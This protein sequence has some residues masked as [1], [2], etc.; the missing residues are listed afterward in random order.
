MGTIR[1]FLPHYTY[2]DYLQWQGQW[3]VIR[4]IAISMSP[5]PSPRHQEI[6]GNI[7]LLL[8]T[9]VKLK[10]CKQCKV[11]QPIDYKISEDTILNPDLLVV[12]KPVEG[13]F[14]DFPPELVV[15]ILSPSTAVK[16]RNTK[17]DLYEN[18]GIKY[19]II[20]NP[21]DESTEVYQLIE[22]K[23]MLTDTNDFFLDG[24]VITVNFKDC[25]E[26]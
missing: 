17:Y 24:C 21:A 5:M 15:E 6:A 23:Y 8:K 9:A 4:G 18:E 1:Q 10:G 25:F 26:D 2:N 3:E 7:H 19:Y 13:Q 11:Y 16:D 20:V 22:G 12:C 14:L